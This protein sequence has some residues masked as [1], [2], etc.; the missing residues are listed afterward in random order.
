MSSA[1]RAGLQTGT[2]AGMTTGPVPPERD[3]PIWEMSADELSDYRRALI[4][5]LRQAPESAP[6]YLE[7]CA[8]LGDV[9]AEGQIRKIIEHFTKRTGREPVRPPARAGLDT[10]RAGPEKA[11]EITE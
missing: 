8:H 5:Y 4:E 6:R 1:R 3:V 11:Q 10:A 7:M 9:V 2:D